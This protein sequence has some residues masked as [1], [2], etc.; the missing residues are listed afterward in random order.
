VYEGLFVEVFKVEVLSP[1]GV[2]LTLSRN[3]LLFDCFFCADE[4]LVA[5]LF[6]KL[7]QLLK[8]ARAQRRY[9]AEILFMQ[10]QYRFQ[11]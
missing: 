6:F 4:L 2:T 10:A 5:E 3:T 11:L 7:L 8:K 1:P 9:S